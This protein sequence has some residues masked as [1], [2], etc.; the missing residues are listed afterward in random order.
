MKRIRRLI[1]S[2]P[3]Q[4]LLGA[5]VGFYVRFVGWTL[6]W[7]RIGLEAPVARFLRHEPLILSF[8]HNRLMLVPLVYPAG[9]RAGVMTSHH[10]DGRI[11]GHAIRH[12]QLDR[13]A[14]SSSQ[15]GEAAA[16]EACRRLERG[17]VVV[18]APDGPR[19]PRMR[20]A[21]GVIRIA[22]IS[23]APIYP[24]S[25]A[26]SRRRVLAN[27]DRFI[28]ALPFGRGLFLIG[29]PI[30]VPADADEAERERLRELLET[31]L[32][33]LGDEADRRLG[34]APIEPA[35]APG[36]KAAR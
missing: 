18:I 25:V 12:F 27:W 28:L 14:G 9:D 35:P 26:C 30:W 13:I 31:R 15:G 17:D 24:L 8:W 19:G 4:A 32:T 5:L 23:G 2:E 34:H 33:R 11:V 3:L 16:I 20:A 1:R 10:R 21:P 7:Q 36:S 29:D 22:Q 6:R